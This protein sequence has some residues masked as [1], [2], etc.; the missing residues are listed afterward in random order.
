M[1]DKINIEYTKIGDYN[2]SNLILSRNK[3]RNYKLDKYGRMRLH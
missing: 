1:N 2:I 3:Y